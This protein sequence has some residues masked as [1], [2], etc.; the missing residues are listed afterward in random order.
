MPDC[1]SV[2]IFMTFIV[3]LLQFMGVRLVEKVQQWKLSKDEAEQFGLAVTLSLLVA[4]RTSQA[5]ANRPQ[6]APQAK[7]MSG[8]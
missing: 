7:C 1:K 6:T 8:Q 2:G 3:H 4:C 5:H